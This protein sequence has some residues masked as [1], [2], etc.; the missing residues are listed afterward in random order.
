M[1]WIRRNW[2]DVLIGAALVAVI[3]G[4]VATLL[5]GG[6][7]LPVGGG[8]VTPTSAQNASPQASA[9]PGEEPDASE[10]EPAGNGSD[11]PGVAVLPPSDEAPEPSEAAAASEA[12]AGSPEATQDEASEPEGSDEAPA[13]EPIDPGDGGNADADDGEAVAAAPEADEAPAPEPDPEP[14][15]DPGADAA[16]GEDDAASAELPTDPYR[17]SVGAFG[18]RENAERQA[19]R[20]RE[21][22]FPVFIGSQDDLSLVLVGPYVDRSQ[23]EGVAARIEDGYDDVDPIIYLYEPELDEGGEQASAGAAVA[24]SQDEPADQAAPSANGAADD[25][26]GARGPVQLQVGAYATPDSAAPQLERLEELGFD[27]VE[28]RDGGLIRVMVGP[29]EGAALDDARTTLDGAGI[30]YF[31]R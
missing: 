19:D 13:V 18:S 14:E 10:N 26:A 11:G 20:F 15:T 25:A 17:V 24:A 9:E 6:S 8:D 31:P 22:G 7:F 28:E 4:I 16:D 2:P 3:A 30:E 27:P 21:D 1:D 23:A 5:T 29:L 12:D